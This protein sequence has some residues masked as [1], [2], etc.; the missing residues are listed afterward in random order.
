M[1]KDAVQ[2]H[3]KELARPKVEIAEIKDVLST[4]RPPQWGHSLYELVFEF[5][6]IFPYIRPQ[7]FAKSSPYFC[8]M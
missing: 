7:N 4:L 6:I 2:C 8:P 3:E 5:F 1:H